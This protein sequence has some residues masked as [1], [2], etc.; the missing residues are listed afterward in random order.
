MKESILVIHGGAPTA[1]INASLYGVIKAAKESPNVVRLL[2]AKGGSEALLGGDFID[3]LALD[4]K[5][6]EQLPHTPG[7]W[8]GTS[9]YQISDRDYAMMVATLVRERITAVL[10][11][12]GNG[13]MDS[14]GKLARAI[15]NHPEASKQGIRIVGIPK[16]IDNDLAVTDHAPGFGSAARYFAASVRELME[17][18]ASLPIHVSVIEGMGRNS[19]WLTASACLANPHMILIPEV[20]FDEERFLDEIQT[21]YNQEG[22]VVVVASEGLKTASGEPIVPPIFEVGRSLYYGDTSAHLAN[23]IIQRLGIKARSEKPGILGR[24]SIAYQSEVDRDEAIGAGEAAVAAVLA[25]ASEVMVGF[26]RISSEPYVCKTILIP[27]EEVMLLERP[28]DQAYYDPESGKIYREE[29]RTWLEP[30]TGPMEDR[31][32]TRL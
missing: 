23:L 8:I 26:E 5:T 14:C 18:V 17:D 13:S 2:A 31:F 6:V 29:Y 22:G 32:A 30:L 10:F 20:S 15:A 3:L 7:S 24:C 9:R 16:T 28:F 21:L 4:T 19:G 27:I 1:V 25:G 12:G 11:T